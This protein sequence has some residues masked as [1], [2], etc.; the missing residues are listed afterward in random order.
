MLVVGFYCFGFLL[1]EELVI[2]LS[3]FFNFG[4]L[5]CNFSL[6]VEMSVFSVFLLILFSIFY[7]LYGFVEVLMGCVWYLL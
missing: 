1:F 5:C 2:K 6:N 7:W 4:K 3:D